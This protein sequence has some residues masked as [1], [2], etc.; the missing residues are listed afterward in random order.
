MEANIPKN[1]SEKF[2]ADVDQKAYYVTRKKK[3]FS[4]ELLYIVWILDNKT[5]SGYI[6]PSTLELMSWKQRWKSLKTIDTTVLH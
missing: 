4:W 3:T 2:L 6:P 1:I 5:L